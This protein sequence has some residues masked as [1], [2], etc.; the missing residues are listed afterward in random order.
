MSHKGEELLT[1]AVTIESEL[2]ASTEE[3]TLSANEH[4][5]FSRMKSL[6]V[7]MAFFKAS[8]R[9]TDYCAPFGILTGVRPAKI[10]LFYLEKGLS[11][12]EAQNVLCE[13]YFIHRNKAVLSVKA[14]KHELIQKKIYGT[15]SCGVYVSIPFCPTRCSYCSFISSAA[16]KQLKMLPQYLELLHGEIET[17]GK[18]CA[19]S[20]VTPR[21]FYIGGGTP[22]I[23][24]ATQTRELM[25][26]LKDSFSIE[27]G[28]ELTFEMGR[29]DTV[30]REKLDALK[31]GGATRLCINTQTTSDR[32]LKNIGRA[33]TA[34]DFFEAYELAEKTGFDKINVDL[35]AGLPGD[36]LIGFKKSLDEVTALKPS[37][38][39][40][41]TL[42]TKKASFDAEA[43]TERNGGE[44]L[45]EM[46]AYS[47]ESL[48]SL[49]YEPYY[50]Y[51]QK[52][53][54]GNYENTGYAL[55]GDICAYNI[56]MMED[57]CT[58][59]SAGAGAVTK[60]I[61]HG[62]GAKRFSSFKYPYEYINQNEKVI[63]NLNAV[64]EALKSL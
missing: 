15:D 10:A 38:I 51:R 43:G 52:N 21:S 29:P 31:D 46:L 45:T 36:D 13:C 47:E 12:E 58:V 63:S 64:S 5:T 6:A 35:I 18:I 3:V 60:V 33:H 48:A 26:V 40:V 4:F 54:I 23:L 9:F 22:G 7:G 49:G 41:H 27:V 44:M 32:V 17:L 53:A 39:T 62:E 16:P 57:V 20:G 56:V 25:K 34:R 19:D 37:N 2:G 50:I 8:R 42:C 61:R 14:A 55:K 11:E 30:T 24:S 1:A 59:L 28:T